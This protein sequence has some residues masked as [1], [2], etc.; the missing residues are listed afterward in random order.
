LV[1]RFSEPRFA[2]PSLL[3]AV[4][5]TPPNPP[6]FAP[7]ASSWRS[8]I[9]LVA[10]VS[11]LRILYLAFFCPYTLLEDEAHY[12][13]WSR[14]LAWAYY[15]KP[16]GVAILI[17]ASTSIF[18]NTEFAV[19]LPAVV[20]SA[21]MSLALAALARDGSGDRRA[22]FF[23][24]ALVQLIPLFQSTS[25]LL[26]I[27]MPYAACWALASWAAWRAF[28][29]PAPRWILL[30]G[31]AAALGLVFKHT[32]LLWLPGLLSFA[33]LHRPFLGRA[34]LIATLSLFGLL[35]NLIWNA[36]RDWPTLRHLMGHLGLAGGDVP[37]APSSSSYSPL[38]TLEFLATQ[39]AL[40]GPALAL[41]LFA[42]RPAA[43]RPIARRFLILTG[44]PIILF[45][46]AITLVTE[47]EGNWA[48][49]GYTTLAALAAWGLVLGMDD[50]TARRRDWL[51]LP[52]P[53]PKAGLLRRSPE[54]ATQVFWHATLALGLLT[55]LAILR[56]DLLARIPVVG[57]SV[58]LSRLID[59]DTIAAH[60]HRLADDL[61]RRTGKPPL[62]ISQFYGRA[63]QLAFYLPGQPVVHCSSSRMNGRKSQFDLW[64]HTDLDDPALAGRPAVLLGDADQ[65]WSWGFT[66]VERVGRLE[67][68][69]K[70]NREAFLGLEYTPKLAP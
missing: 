63:S 34:L 45:Y 65:D 48:F 17:A 12:W 38:W 27:D 61:Q 44:L 69:R 36:Q 19:R 18:G 51:A 40:V 10:A 55:A 4:T 31:L 64:S 7:W 24:A 60:V 42:F 6:L 11:L 32:M 39:I 49:A 54:T 67:G 41:M 15:S 46:L 1:A 47:P 9:I 68:D 21:A 52:V 70:R 14:H 3:L 30:A 33:F 66:T 16:P 43:D 8:V 57:P 26:T 58:P 22:G 5:D 37:T 56:L 28:T 50:F 29:T 13:D 20:C 35:P 25:L 2:S 59:A 53:R 62:I 23:A